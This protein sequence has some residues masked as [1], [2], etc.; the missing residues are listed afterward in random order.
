M[1]VS[2]AQKD[3]AWGKKGALYVMN[4]TS[5]RFYRKDGHEMF[6]ADMR[7][8]GNFKEYDMTQDGINFYL[9]TGVLIIGG[10]V[11]TKDGSDITAKP[12]HPDKESMKLL[13]HPQIF[14]A[15]KINDRIKELSKNRWLQCI[16]NSTARYVTY[17]LN[18][19]IFYDDGAVSGMKPDYCCFVNYRGVTKEEEAVLWARFT[20]RTGKEIFY[21]PEAF[22]FIGIRFFDEYGK[23]KDF[24][25]TSKPME[26]KDMVAPTKPMMPAP[27]KY[28]TLNQV[29]KDYLKAKDKL[30]TGTSG[31]FINLDALEKK[32]LT[33]KEIL[34]MFW[35]TG[36]ILAK[37]DQPKEGW[38]ILKSWD[39][40]SIA[41]VHNFKSGTEFGDACGKMCH[42]YQVKR[43]SDGEIITV[44]DTDKGG[45]KVKRIIIRPINH[46]SS[47]QQCWLGFSDGKGDDNGCD[48]EFFKPKNHKEIYFITED[49][50]PAIE[51]EKY[52][53][54]T[55]LDQCWKLSEVIMREALKK[56]PPYFKYFKDKGL[57]ET[58]IK[59]KKPVFNLE[60]ILDTLNGLVSDE[61]WI[62]LR[63]VFDNLAKHKLSNK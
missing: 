52:W 46:I 48:L 21:V 29:V 32:E 34:N 57:A 58:Y 56:P 38:E 7:I 1:R 62:N 16:H 31:V 63:G 36:Y 25:R 49:G 20:K 47:K 45:L 12:V 33:P 11:I 15:D 54:T 14:Y 35:E 8:S 30:F 24:I 42:P 4:S 50:Y 28:I 10:K 17:R 2:I 60:N 13:D 19:R 43:L 61:I 37:P 39:G 23:S 6:L 59:L 18:D 9:E 40:K 3:F 5:G 53:T 44:G 26:E 55:S 41:M 22:K 51:G 27:P